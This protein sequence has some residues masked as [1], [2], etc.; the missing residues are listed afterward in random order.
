VSDLER[1]SPGKEILDA[2]F[3]AL[4]KQ[5]RNAAIVLAMQALD[6]GDKHPLFLN[7]RSFWHE[8]QG[9]FADALSDLEEAHTLAPDDIGVLNALG[10]AYLRN[11]RL[12]EALDKFEAAA[13]LDR[14]FLHAQLNRAMVRERLGDLDEARQAYEIVVAGDPNAYAALGSL[15]ALAA[16]RSDWQAVRENAARV[17]AVDPRQVNANYA[18]ALAETAQGTPRAAV[19]RL[20]PFAR[21]ANLAPISRALLRGALAD[22]FDASGAY[23]EAFAW[24]SAAAE[25]LV[26][27]HHAKFA[28]QQIESA[29]AYVRRVAEYVRQTPERVTKIPT[30]KLMRRP[31]H[32]GVHCFLLGFP[33]SGT[34][35]LEN[36]LAAHPEVQTSDE[37]EGF[38][39]SMREFMTL[40]AG[41]T[42]LC[43]L[44]GN[45]LSGY[46]DAYWRE[47]RDKGV[48]FN[49][50]VFVDKY[51][52]N[53]LK[54]PLIARIFPDAKILL[55][56][57]DPR[58]VVLSCFRRRFTMNASM[59]EFTNLIRA[60]E[61]F[62]SV[63]A[64]AQ[65]TL[66]AFNLSPLVTRYEEFVEAFD[67]RAPEICRFLEIEWTSEVLTFA[68]SAKARA[69]STPSSAQVVRGIYQE[70]VGQWRHYEAHLRPIFPILRPWIDRFGY[71]S[72]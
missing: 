54:L 27:A 69:I 61:F 6:S 7:L 65:E 66:R 1:H 30:P 34:T 35:L 51:P 44:G 50:R 3:G 42:K 18:L 10:I 24:Y 68:E 14:N 11:D 45:E 59:Y 5:D 40:P 41:I 8:Q 63:M 37:K 53:T 47:L 56:V 60:A 49:T 36:V 12:R 19:A 22:A 9:R 38:A 39:A 64:F 2:V 17:L 29:N 13:S 52:L 55:A 32:P 43:G 70:G 21:D 28:G 62:D 67:A 72:R 58:D 46:R 25:D 57:R 31:E 26:L 15:A 48:K 16:R 23:D 20:M 4:N 71:N 33:R